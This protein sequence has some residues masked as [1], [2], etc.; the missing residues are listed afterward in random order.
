VTERTV[1]MQLRKPMKIDNMSHV[2]DLG[3]ATMASAPGQ[4][5]DKPVRS[6]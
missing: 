1:E 4:E 3:A 2:R 5:L 6:A